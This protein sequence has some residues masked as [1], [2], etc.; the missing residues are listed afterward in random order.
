M[1]K[2]L[3]SLSILFL[4]FTFIN[5]E[6]E[7]ATRVIKDVACD[8]TFSNSGENIGPI[9][10]KILDYNGTSPSISVYYTNQDNKFHRETF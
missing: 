10:I 6:I 4:S 7:A 2:L 8:Y 3:F 1:K 9:Q 5:I